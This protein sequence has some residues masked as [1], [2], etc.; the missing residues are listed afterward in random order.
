MNNVD[1]QPHSRACGWLPH[2]HGLFCSTNCPTC[3]G[4]PLTPSPS[5]DTPSDTVTPAVWKPPFPSGRRNYAWTPHE[6]PNRNYIRLP[7]NPTRWPA[8]NPR[9][10]QPRSSR[11][12][13]ARPWHPEHCY[14]TCC[15]TRLPANP[16]R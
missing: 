2:D 7:D 11:R 6:W 14:A 9:N 4:K 15:W 13:D 3:S 12:P 8:P 10:I 5:A 16:T 1:R